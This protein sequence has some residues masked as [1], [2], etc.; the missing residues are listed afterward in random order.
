MS[1]IGT[2]F[3]SAGAGFGFGAGAGAGMSMPGICIPEW[4]CAHAGDAVMTETRQAP[5]NN[6]ICNGLT[7]AL[8]RMGKHPARHC[9]HRD[10]LTQRHKPQWDTAG[11]AHTGAFQIA[12]LDVNRKYD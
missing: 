3:A 7:P 12:L 1:G 10:V 4:S 5:A 11:S 8:H 2:G 6:R 9:H